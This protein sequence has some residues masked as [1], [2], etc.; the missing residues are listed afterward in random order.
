MLSSD[1]NIALSAVG[2]PLSYWQRP[3]QFNKF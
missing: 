2:E 1:E 3:A